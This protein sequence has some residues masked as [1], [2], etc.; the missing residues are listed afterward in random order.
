MTAI[1]DNGEIEP[2][3]NFAVAEHHTY[4]VASQD[5]AVSALVHNAYGHH[6]VPEAVTNSLTSIL[7]KEAKDLFTSSTTGQL[8]YN[9]G[10]DT[11][12]GVT[13]AEYS[14]AVKELL[15]AYQKS[16][17]GGKLNIEQANAFLNL[18][19]NGTE[20]K[21]FHLTEANQK[22]LQKIQTWTKGFRQSVV[23]AEAAATQNPKL[24]AQ[25]LKN[26]AKK[27]VN[28]EEVTLSKAAAKTLGTI[29]KQ[30]GL[31]KAAAKKVF[32]GLIFYSYVNAAKEGYS[33]GVNGHT[34]AAGAVMGVGRDMVFADEIEALVFPL[35]D[36]ASDAVE[37]LF[38]GGNTFDEAA[39]DVLNKRLKTLG[40]KP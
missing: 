15:T 8:A 38:T 2:V 30:K 19:S 9:H 36:S 21:D 35:A 1:V 11:W 28:K 16:V 10:F 33:E 3:Y 12:L 4:F 18:I 6:W 34:G 31:L 40:G 25:E 32:P 22:V 37:K 27:I 7:S 26:L 14:N 39:E 24:T 5:G 17:G 23:V 13:H 29:A 20:I